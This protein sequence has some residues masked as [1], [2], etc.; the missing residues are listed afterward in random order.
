MEL[1]NRISH[2]KPSA[3]MAVKEKASMLKQQGKNIIDLSVGEP[4]FNTPNHI[5]EAAIKALSNNHT[6]YTSSKGIP[7]LRKQ[8]S[9]KLQ[10]ENNLTTDPEKNILVTPGTKQALYYL[11]CVIINPG[12][13]AI[14]FE[15]YWVTYPESIKLC[16]GI[17]VPVF[18]K[19]ENNFK[20]TIKEIEE[21]ITE[22]T[23]YILFSNPCNPTGALFN[24]EELQEIV[25][26]AK[27]RNIYIISDE[28]Y[29]YIIYDNEFVSTASLSRAK[30]ITI[31]LNGFSKG[32][33]MTGWRIAFIAA[34]EHII[35]AANIMQQQ[36]ATCA[37]SIS[38]K[39]AVEAYNE[40]HKIKDMVQKYQQ[41]R[42]LLVNGLNKIKGFHCN[43]PKGTFYT[44]PNISGLNMNS[45]KAAEYILEHAQITTVPGIAYG[46][47][48]DSFLRFSFAASEEDIK[49]A[50][51]RLEKLFG[52]S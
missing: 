40:K 5:K 52:C 28:I 51:N 2:I 21:K 15:P 38:Q 46:E 45:T 19:E 9:I 20:P 3:S 33:N 13:E 44:F 30:D 34:P 47:N 41:N 14:I 35:K 39:A 42:D 31:T 7:E 24:K 10:Q 16:G 32:T 25:N 36:I 8:I 43:N 26:L 22:K 48:C 49:E 29:E 4:H 11:N 1:S 12:D 17:P 50:L 27:E 6:K 23:K 18:G 37:S